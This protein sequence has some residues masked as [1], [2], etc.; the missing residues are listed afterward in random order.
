LY[1]FIAH[2]VVVGNNRP[3][4]CHGCPAFTQSSIRNDHKTALQLQSHSP[5]AGLRWTFGSRGKHDYEKELSDQSGNF[6]ARTPYIKPADGKLKESGGAV[7]SLDLSRDPD[8]RFMYLINQNDA[9][10][11]VLDRESGKILST[12]VARANIRVNSIRLTGSPSIPRAMS[13]S[14]KIAAGGCRNSS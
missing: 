2:W 12:L 4:P 7:V 8:E 14:L 1:S 6:R 9:V 5:R 11:E 3:V 10:V 13:T